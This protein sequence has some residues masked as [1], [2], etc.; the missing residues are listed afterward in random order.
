MFI[1]KNHRNTDATRNATENGFTKTIINLIS[2]RF[3][4]F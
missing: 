4:Q 1:Y 2:D 3:G